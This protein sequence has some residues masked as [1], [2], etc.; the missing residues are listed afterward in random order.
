MKFDIIVA[1]PPYN[2]DM[3]LDFVSTAYDMLKDDGMAIFITP[4]KFYAKGGAKN[5]AFRQKIMPHIKEAHIY[6]NSTDV[7]DIGELGGIAYY[8]VYKSQVFSTKLIQTHC[9]KNKILNSGLEEHIEQPTEFIQQNMLNLI[10]KCKAVAANKLLIVNNLMK[11]YYCSDTFT[12]HD[13]RLDTDLPFM[14]GRGGQLSQEGYISLSELKR[15]DNIN[16]YK[17]IKNEQ[18]CSKNL[19]FDKQGRT[20]GLTVAQIIEPNCIP[21]GSYV[22][23]GWCDTKEEAESL[24]SYLNSGLVSVI[25]MNSLA[26]N[27]STCNESWRHVPALPISYSFDHIYT[28]EEI[29]KIFEL[30][31]EEIKL[32]TNLIKPR[33]EK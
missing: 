3:Y 33:K 11:C 12:G 18:E 19:G 6:K 2:K 7:F 26:A 20:L 27:K 32:I 17:V 4:A 16:K 9:L 24:A 30:T 14:S 15:S 10:A 25:V 28:N 8:I 21:K 29:F 23:Y 31:D 13:K 1:N 5:E 22:I